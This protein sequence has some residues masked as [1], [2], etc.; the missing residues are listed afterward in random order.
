MRRGG[1]GASAAAQ[2]ASRIPAGHPEGYLEGFA[3][4]Y[5]DAAD[6]IEAHKAGTAAPASMLPGVGA[7]VDGMR[8]ITAAL[9]SAAAEGRWTPLNEGAR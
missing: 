1:P 3:Q 2:A 9:A 4:I 8:F 5:A 6:L 7:G